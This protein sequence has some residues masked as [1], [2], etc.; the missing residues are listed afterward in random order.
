MAASASGAVECGLP[1]SEQSADERETMEKRS[2]ATSHCNRGRQERHH[3]A[4]V[5]TAGAHVVG[6]RAAPMHLLARWHRSRASGAHD[7]GAA[8]DGGREAVPSRAVVPHAGPSR[9]RLPRNGEGR[10]SGPQPLGEEGD[11]NVHPI[12]RGVQEDDTGLAVVHGERAR[13]V[14]PMSA[15]DQGHL[16][17][18]AAPTRVHLVPPC[19]HDAVLLHPLAP[20]GAIHLQVAAIQEDERDLQVAV[21]ADAPALAGHRDDIPPDGREEARVRILHRVFFG[22]RHRRLQSADLGG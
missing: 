11:R 4:A 8:C 21:E 19:S 15:G 14:W 5:A 22:S 6:A 3:L 20:H 18:C 13:Q 7:A 9:P 12:L 2:A 17:P 10:R 16:V 1:R